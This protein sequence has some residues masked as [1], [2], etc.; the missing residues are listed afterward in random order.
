MLQS[1]PGSFSG[2]LSG[3]FAVLALA[4]LTAGCATSPGPLYQ[5]GTFPRQQYDVL[6]RGGASPV[7]QIR[8]MEAHAVKVRAA[9]AALPPGFRAHLGM[10][11]LSLGDTQGAKA[12]W[13]AEKT[14]FPEATH[15]MDRLLKNVDPPA[16]GTAPKEN[17]A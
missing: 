5:W 16:A 3:S 15:Y 10:L 6:L 11:K 8:A 17:P 14:A 12:A 2:R 7:E 1:L 9:N 4:A 13:E